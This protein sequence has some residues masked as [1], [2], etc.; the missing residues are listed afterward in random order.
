MWYDNYIDNNG[1]IILDDK[2]VFDLL[3]QG[4]NLTNVKCKRSE[5][6]EIYN[7]IVD[8]Y[9]LNMSKLQFTSST[10]DKEKF[11]Q[12]CLNNWFIPEKY[13][14]INPYNYIRELVKTQ[15]EIDRVELEIQ[16]FEERNMKN[17]LRFMIFF[18][19]FMRENNIV[20][21]VGRGSSVAS[22]CLYLLG[23]H[24]VNSLHHDLDIKEFLK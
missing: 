1:E 3:Y 20:W 2:A 14:N 7:S 15:E 16:M 18:I 17:V 6:L 5:D 12:K 13:K 9:D 19:D 22:Y 4:S 10:E 11:I 21:G 8:E 24:K 23:V